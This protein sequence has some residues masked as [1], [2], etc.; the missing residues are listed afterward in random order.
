MPTS[1]LLICIAA[2]CTAASTLMAQPAMELMVQPAGGITRVWGNHNGNTLFSNDDA[3][4]RSDGTEYQ[5]FELASHVAGEP[6]PVGE[7]LSDFFYITGPQGGSALWVTDG[8]PGNETLL[9]NGIVVHHIVEYDGDA[10]FW[11]NDG[12]MTTST[13]FVTDG[14][15]GGTQPI[16]GTAHSDPDTAQA[17]M[18]VA[19]NKLVFARD[20]EI[21][22][23]DGSGAGTEQLM[24]INSSGSADAQVV[25]ST[26]GKVL[27]IANDGV[28]GRQLYST[29]GTPSGTE[30]ISSSPVNLWASGAP[31]VEMTGYSI[32]TLDHGGGQLELWRTD[33]TEIGTFKLT[34]LAAV[35]MNLQP[36]PTQ[37][38]RDDLVLYFV[39]YGPGGNE[40]WKTDGTVAGTQFIKN[41]DTGDEIRGIMIHDGVIYLAVYEASSSKVVLWWSDGTET[42]TEFFGTIGIGSGIIDFAGRWA[43]R[44]MFWADGYPGGPLWV[45]HTTHLTGPEPDDDDDGEGNG[46]GGSGSNGG[47]SRSGG[48]GGGGGCTAVAAPGAS[49]WWLLA[50]GLLIAVLV[51]RRRTATAN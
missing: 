28:N 35:N 34:D 49:A 39:A 23:S 29:D 37:R 12:G 44:M 16:S 24:I 30:R 6:R 7:A 11:A 13:L 19:H 14:T 31:Q 2:V 1:R 27:F 10:Y 50:A 51:R 26:V 22:I 18:Y 41:M 42:G 17:P 33:T 25:G 43:E 3:V 5:T 40:F 46:N 38:K 15:V 48:N 8:I 36:A 4:W 9:F 47:S 45:L 21:W 32:L 20:G